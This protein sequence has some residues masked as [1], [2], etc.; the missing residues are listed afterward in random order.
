MS[1]KTEETR[2]RILDASVRMLEEHG[3]LGVRMSD[4]AKATGLSRQ[5]LYLHFS[6]RADLLEATTQH[7]DQALDL[8]RRLAPSRTAQNGQERMALYIEFW[9][10]YI[11]DI[12]AVS[13][14]LMV[15]QE[16]DEAA[17]KAWKDR[18][19][20]M[21]DGCRAAIKALHADGDLKKE[22]SQKQ[23][24]DV[25][26]TMLLVPAW[27]NLVMECGWSN[28]QYVKW[29][30]TIAIQVFVKESEK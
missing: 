20:A 2:L 16:T 11:P 21:R 9:G 5:A 6:S 14:A 29:M 15:A 23:A 19:E 22:W 18:M 27:E 26:W 8:D 30:K 10:K 1:S 25:L 12:Y 7:V 13:K 4:I 24:T 3:G 17:A 28:Q